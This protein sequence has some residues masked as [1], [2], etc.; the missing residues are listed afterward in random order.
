MLRCPDQNRITVPISPERDDP[1]NS[2]T[3]FVNDD[4]SRVTTSEFGRT[5]GSN[6]RV[7]LTRIAATGTKPGK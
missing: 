6:S 7:S 3:T 1:G 4:L 5:R 2:G